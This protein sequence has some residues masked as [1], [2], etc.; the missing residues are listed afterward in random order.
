MSKHLFLSNSC[1]RFFALGERISA[2][3]GSS[4]LY[5]GKLERSANIDAY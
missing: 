5:A 1:P 2:C 3:G 4:G